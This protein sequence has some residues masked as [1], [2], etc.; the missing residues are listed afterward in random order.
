M[1]HRTI[2]TYTHLAG[3]NVLHVI[4]A[5]F[6]PEIRPNL[7][8]H[9]RVVGAHTQS[10]GVGWCGLYLAALVLDQPTNVYNPHAADGNFGLHSK[11]PVPCR[12]AA[13]LCVLTTGTRY[14]L[15]SG[16]ACGFLV[17]Q[18]HIPILLLLLL[19]LLFHYWLKFGR[20]PNC[21]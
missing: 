4:I 19:H 5:S 17:L 10:V 20:A 3:W 21:V 13:V 11:E 2:P 15:K 18:P 12:A 7:S 1:Q 16:L 14:T 9:L 8:P 6:G